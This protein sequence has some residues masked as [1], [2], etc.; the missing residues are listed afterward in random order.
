MFRGTWAVDSHHTV[1]GMYR[2]VTAAALVPKSTAHLKWANTPITFNASD[3]QEK[4]TGAG[5]LSLVTSPTITNIKVHHVL[6][7]RGAAISAMSLHA[8]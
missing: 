3:Y 2:D 4:M 6:I 7:D 1:K 5:Q 8:F